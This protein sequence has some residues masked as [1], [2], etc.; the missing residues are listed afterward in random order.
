MEP[1][2]AQASARQPELKEARAAPVSVRRA[3]IRTPARA[4]FSGGPGSGLVAAGSVLNGG[5]TEAQ[6]VYEFEVVT[7]QDGINQV[8]DILTSADQE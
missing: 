6:R 7:D 4:I 8:T 5:F 2:R 1:A 3:E